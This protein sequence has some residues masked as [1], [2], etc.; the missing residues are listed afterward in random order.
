MKNDKGPMKPVAGFWFFVLT[1]LAMCALCASQALAQVP[2]RFYWKSLSD[3]NAVPLILNYVSGNT[4]PFN[5]ANTPTAGADI[6]AFLATPGYARTFSLFDRAA[7]AALL[8]PMGHI[9]GE[10]TVA[11]RTFKQSANGWGDPMLEFTF[12]ILG[13]P[14]QK[15]IPD[16]L[17]YEPGFSVD[18]L[19]DLAIPIGKYDSDQP[20]N[21]GQNRWYGRVGAPIVWQLGSWVPGRRTTLEFLPSV[22]FFSTNDDYVGQ[23]LKTDPKFQLDAHLTRDFTER[24]WGSLDAAWYYGGKSSINGVAGEKLNNLGVGLTL[25]Y[26]INDNL[27]LT[28][29]YKTTVNDKGSGDLRMSSFMLTLVYGWHPLIEGMKRLKEGEK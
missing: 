4:N 5:P 22:W 1:M 13:P 3:A 25:G 17:R 28:F 19:A 27:Q 11:G 7:M 23:T 6:D 20:L 16:V 18:L 26:Q 21:L 2:A 24:F 15:N 9:S 8:L 10:I 14:A 29:G 12:N